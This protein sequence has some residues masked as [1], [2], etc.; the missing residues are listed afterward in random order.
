[1]SLMQSRRLRSYRL[2]VR[3][4]PRTVEDAGAEA[5]VQPA[6]TVAASI[7]GPIP[8]LAA[9]LAPHTSGTTTLLDADG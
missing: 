2:S 8:E 7:S 5:P 1:M 9:D 3:A 6:W 4:K